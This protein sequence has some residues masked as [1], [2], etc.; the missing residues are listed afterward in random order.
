MPNDKKDVQI[1]KD[2]YKVYSESEDGRTRKW[3]REKATETLAFKSNDRKEY[4][5]HTECMVLSV[6]CTLVKTG[7]LKIV[8]E[9]KQ[10][11]KSK[12]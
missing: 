8:E 7:K 6:I 5:K 12:V 11:G 9:V 3:V 2:V 1:S 4:L 10:S